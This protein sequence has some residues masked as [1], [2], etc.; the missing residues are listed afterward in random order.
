LTDMMSLDDYMH[1]DEIWDKMPAEDS[2]PFQPKAS[3][4][5]WF[6]G[7]MVALDTQPRR[8]ETTNLSPS[9]VLER[10]LTQRDRLSLLIDP[11]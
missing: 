11:G 9:E 1:L 3:D 2:C 8:G 5:A 7:R 6:E 10:S 4:W